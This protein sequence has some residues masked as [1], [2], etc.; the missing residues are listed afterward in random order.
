MLRAQQQTITFVAI[1][2]SLPPAR[3][4]GL[5]SWAGSEVQ[6]SKEG[7]AWVNATNSPTEIGSSGR[8]ALVL[9][10]T[11]C[12]CSWLHVKVEKTGMQPADEPG[13]MDEQYDGA[14]VADAGNGVLGFKTDLASV[15][16]DFYKDALIRFTTGALAGSGPKRIS[17]YSTGKIVTLA[18]AL[19]LAPSAGDLFVVV[20]T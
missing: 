1:D 11:E 14:V 10:A 3:K 19:P 20:T 5:T 16:A 9:T 2:S 8:Y 4:S 12:R 6:I 13:S 15:V 17:A 7:A 18:S